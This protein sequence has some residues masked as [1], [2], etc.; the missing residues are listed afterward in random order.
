MH[1]RAFNSIRMQ[2]AAARLH[3]ASRRLP[4]RPDR[5]EYPVVCLPDAN[6]SPPIA[7]NDGSNSQTTLPCPR[8]THFQDG[9]GRKRDS[10]PLSKKQILSELDFACV[11]NSRT[12]AASTFGFSNRRSRSHLATGA[13]VPTILRSR[14]S[15]VTY[16]Q[17][18]GHFQSP[19]R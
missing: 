1:D 14:E 7:S 16:I 9:R 8:Q 6:L 13:S 4:R 17:G 12:F 2:V 19:L 15:P 11:S 5:R 3:F 10:T 18:I